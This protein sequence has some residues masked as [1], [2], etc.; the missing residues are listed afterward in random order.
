MASL[1]ELA[2]RRC[3]ERIFWVGGMRVA[4]RD[5]MPKQEA[6]RGKGDVFAPCLLQFKRLQWITNVKEKDVR[7]A[8]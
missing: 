1:D 6:L 7:K 2:D 8:S 5:L 3:T 4:Y